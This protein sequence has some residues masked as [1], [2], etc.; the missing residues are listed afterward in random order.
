MS[1]YVI[2][3]SVIKRLPRYYRFLGELKALGMQKISSRELSERM[4]L[5]ASQIRQDLNCFGGFGQQGYGYNIEILQAEIA[6]ILGI[7]IPKSAILIGMGNLG[8]A[9]TMHINFESKGFHLVGLFDCK[10]SLLGQVVKNLPI[11]SIMSLDEFCRENRPEVAIL[12]I[13]KTSANDIAKQLVKLGVKAFWNFS[14]FDISMNYPDVIVEN[15]H[16]SDSLMRLSYRINSNNNS[17][18]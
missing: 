1:K 6:S 11:R 9:V 18:V 10:E 4:G 12:C 16:F 14:H 15:V 7:D 5:T 17:E 3:N 2:S 13:P 8:R